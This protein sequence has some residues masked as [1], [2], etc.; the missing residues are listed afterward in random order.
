MQPSVDQILDA[1]D[2]SR[3]R[4]YEIKDAIFALLPTLVRP[5]GRPRLEH[6]RAPSST[7]A[8]LRVQALRF[9]MQHPGCVQ[10]GARARYS[11]RYRRFVLELRERHAD[12]T[13]R[14]AA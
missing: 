13:R 2:V 11:E 1:L 10:S 12:V 9:V 7:L 3:S 4:A 8:D 5:P 6:E 14:S